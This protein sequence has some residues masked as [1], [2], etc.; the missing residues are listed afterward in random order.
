M[1]G[2]GKQNI[3]TVAP[4]A[5]PAVKRRRRAAPDIELTLQVEYVSGPEAESLARTQHAAIREVLLWAASQHQQ[6]AA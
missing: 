6:D 4:A 2:D 3:P 1:S 5:P